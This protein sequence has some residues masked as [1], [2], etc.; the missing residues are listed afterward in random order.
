M[1]AVVVASATA[2]PDADASA[3]YAKREFSVDDGIRA[4]VSMMNK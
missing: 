2:A 4:I 1:F 3:P